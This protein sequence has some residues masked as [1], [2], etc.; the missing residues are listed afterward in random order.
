MSVSQ[1][2]YFNTNQS[3]GQYTKITSTADVVLASGANDTYYTAT[4]S[5]KGMYLFFVNYETATTVANATGVYFR[6]NCTTSA[7]FDSGYT[8]PIENTTLPVGTGSNQ[9]YIGF[10]PIT[11]ANTTITFINNPLFAGGTLTRTG[12]TIYFVRFA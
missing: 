8:Y 10:I 11:Q 4:F 12:Y 2:S 6:M 9:S 3:L 7:G 1:S 5:T